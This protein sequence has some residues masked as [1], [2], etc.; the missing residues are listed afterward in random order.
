MSQE[1][2]SHVP[3]GKEA[4][5]QEERSHVPRGKEPC[6]K[7]KGAMSQE[8]RSH[9]PRGKEPCPKKEGFKSAASQVP[10]GGIDIYKIIEK[11]HREKNLCIFHIMQLSDGENT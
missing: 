10:H 2:R 7:R 6:P 3:R 9:V 5:S 11:E 1:E 4:M 8:E